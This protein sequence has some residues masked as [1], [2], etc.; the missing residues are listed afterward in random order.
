MAA[1]AAALL[2]VAAAS[3]AT[4]LVREQNEGW[5]AKEH[6]ACTGVLPASHPA[7][8]CLL[9][10]KCSS[11]SYAA[12]VPYVQANGNGSA[13]QGTSALICFTPD[14]LKLLYVATDDDVY[15][16]YTQCHDPVWQDDALELMLFPGALAADPAGNY[17]EIDISPHVSEK[18]SI[19]V[20]IPAACLYITV[21][22]SVHDCVH[23]NGRLALP[24]PV[25]LSES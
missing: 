3:S 8:P 2:S 22:L 10:P 5:T 16:Q 4:L 21:P 1:L 14:E 18:K 17:T 9:I 6:D 7:V 13:I 12:A 25:L 19:R 23:S 24:H 11:G 20:V 15:S